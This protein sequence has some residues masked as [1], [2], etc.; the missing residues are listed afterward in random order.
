MVNRLMASDKNGDGKLTT[1]ELPERMQ[2]L[3]ARGDA[4]KDGALTKE[5][6]TA[7]M[8]REGGAGPGRGRGG[9]GGG[10]GPQ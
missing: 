3:M 5:E 6:L 7:L 4:N 2:S 1:E 8:S 10:R 9:E